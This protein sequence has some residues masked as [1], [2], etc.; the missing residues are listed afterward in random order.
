MAIHQIL[1]LAAHPQ[2][3]HRPRGIESHA[4]SAD[5]ARLYDASPGAALHYLD[6]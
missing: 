1:A 3:S 2:V 4:A 5:V 6:R